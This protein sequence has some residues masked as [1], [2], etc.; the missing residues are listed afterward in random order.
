MF[1]LKPLNCGDVWWCWDSPLPAGLSDYSEPSAAQRAGPCCSAAP[2]AGPS[3]I[4]PWTRRA[5]PAGWS[6]TGETPPSSPRSA[7]GRTGVK[8]MA[9]SLM[10]RPS[11]DPSAPS[12]LLVQLVDGS[13]QQ[14]LLLLQVVLAPL[15]RLPLQVPLLQ[16]PGQ[17]VPLFAHAG[18]ASLGLLQLSL[19]GAVLS[20][21][22]V[23]LLLGVAAP[24]HAGMKPRLAN[25]N[26][27]IALCSL[28]LYSCYRLSFFNVK[29]IIINLVMIT[30]VTTHLCLSLPY[31]NRGRLK[32]KPYC[33]KALWK[34]FRILE[35]WA[36]EDLQGLTCELLCFH[37]VVCMR[38]NKLKRPL[39][40][41]SC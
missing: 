21:Q 16:P 34:I 2:P 10:S 5:A 31:S 32:S 9:A 28:Y 25:K 20:F 4:A 23:Q 3:W 33:A 6:P 19:Q 30:M 27:N 37:N 1:A 11:D 8:V 22:S 7:S 26:P 13:I 39:P 38:Y 29:K 17:F 14:P 18:S 24:R 41:L 12:H 36:S 35:L 15:Q 40:F